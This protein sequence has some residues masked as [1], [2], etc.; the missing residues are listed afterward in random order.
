MPQVKLFAQQGKTNEELRL[1][2]QLNNAAP[3]KAR[4][5]AAIKL[6]EY[7]VILPGEFP[8][9]MQ[10]A[11]H[12]A[13]MARN[14]SKPIKYAAGLA[15]AT[16]VEGLV[17]IETGNDQKVIQ[18]LRTTKDSSRFRLL[19]TFA[20]S[21]IFRETDHHF[22][23]AH[24]Y[25]SQA[26]NLAR[27]LKQPP[28]ILKA[29][30]LIAEVNYYRRNLYEA[31]KYVSELFDFVQQ[32]EEFHEDVAFELKKI[33][34]M[35]YTH[36]N[37]D[38][39]LYFGIKAVKIGEKFQ[40]IN[41]HR[42]YD[43]LAMI[44]R[45]TNQHAKVIEY[46]EK[47]YKE[48]TRATGRHFFFYISEIV[49]SMLMLGRTKEALPYVKYYLKDVE[50][51]FEDE[52]AHAAVALG[53][54][55]NAIGQYDAAEREYIKAVKNS[56]DI[57]FTKVLGQFYVER[58]QF[59]KARPLLETFA[60]EPVQG[61]LLRSNVEMLLFKVDSAAGKW[62]AAIDHLILTKKM[63][64]SV[65]QATKYRELNELQI[66]YDTEKKDVDILHKSQQIELLDRLSG[67]QRKDLASARLQLQMEE[68]TRM[69]S[70]ALAKSEAARKDRDILLKQQ[71]IQL[72]EQQQ[73]I[74]SAHLL[75]ATTSRNF[76]IAG[77]V[78]LMLL[79][80]VM[81]NRYR[82]K[83]LTTL[84]L[85]AQQ[86]AINQKNAAL[87]KLLNEKEWLLKEVHHRVKNNL[88]TVISLLESQSA[89]L[90]NDALNAIK[91]S[92]HRVYAMSLIH[93]KLYQADDVTSINLGTYIP[94]LV[95]NLA[96]SFDSTRTQ[97]KLE[98]AN[99]ELDVS[100]AI[101]VALI[102]NE[103]ITNALKYAFLPSQARR[104]IYV[105]MQPIGVQEMVLVIRDN[106]R[107]LPAQF[108]QAPSKSLGMR[109]MQGLTGD[110]NGTL[111][112]HS[113]QGVHIRVQFPVEDILHP[114]ITPNET[115]LPVNEKPHLYSVETGFNGAA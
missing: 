84:R 90:Q 95:Y 62:Q 30:R 72:L 79:L 103:A 48:Y 18:L 35:Y 40:D 97:F 53:N 10:K 87:E 92:Q 4:A 38:R 43:N 82:V 77:A 12:Y 5:N 11:M 47:A 20:A 115:V 61:V 80:G 96:E 1:L 6:G 46:L 41:L 86:L 9:D 104:E 22:D 73:L 36:G 17:Y 85:E 114:G 74:Q 101:P 106:G 32:H 45:G 113:H 34:V 59:E 60:K 105:Q 52:I 55:Y 70:T 25:A 94:E 63:D 29:L 24:I 91:D 49:S 99:V 58:K 102:L 57:R 21:Y 7:F 112:M 31:E 56:R 65:Q 69:Q 93:Q 110:L 68:T 44:Y 19:T 51:Q 64:D 76:L 13:Q 15:A 54:S 89:Y 33:S 108:D 67:L 27:D 66:K 28:F 83:K 81:Y 37:L 71:N 42:Y 75:Q 100:Q 3:G 23:S 98:I 111:E 8:G 78:M 39:A 26:L 107:G 2:Q 109:L 16:T 14:E 88:Q 50:P